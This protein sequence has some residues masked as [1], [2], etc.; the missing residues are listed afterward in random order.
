MELIRRLLFI[1]QRLTQCSTAG[2]QC[3]RRFLVLEHLDARRLMVAEGELYALSRTIDTSH[4]G[5]ALS[6]NII[7]GD[8]TTSSGQVEGGRGPEKVRVRVDYSLDTSNFFTAPRR[9]LLQSVVDSIAGK[10]SDT[11]RPIEPSGSN[12]W[13]ATLVHPSTGQLTTQPNLRIAADEIL[14]FA[15]A[16]PMPG[17]Q[18]GEGGPGGFSVA[19]SSQFISDVATRGQGTVSGGSATD[20]GPWGGMVS[21]DSTADWYFGTD[22][23]ALPAG[24]SDFVSLAAHEF[25]H[26][27]GFGTSD[28]WKRHV[29][30]SVFRGPSAKAQYDGGGDVPLASDK[31]HWQLDLMDNGQETLMDPDQKVGTRKVLTP[32][33]WGA[34]KDIGWQF[35]PP[36]AKVTA[37]HAFP[38]NGSYPV[39]VTVVGSQ[40]GTATSG[41]Q[42]NVTNAVPQLTVV[43]SQTV[44]VGEPLTLPK[45]V[46]ISDP[47]FRNTQV[48]PP[49]DETFT[50]EITW[51]DGS[52]VSRGSATIDRVGSAALATL[53]SVSASHTFGQAGTYRVDV[54]VRDDDGA[55]ASGSF[56]VTVLA[57]PSLEI[58][59]NR[60]RIH[61]DGSLKATITL[62]RRNGQLASPL[63]VSVLSSDTTEATVP[64]TVSFAANQTSLT[65]PVEPVDDDLLDGDQTIQIRASAPGVTPVAVDLIVADIEKLTAVFEVAT[66]DENAGPR[67]A[68]LRVTRSNTDTGNPLTVQVQGGNPLTLRP[69]TP[70]IIPVGQQTSTFFLDAIDDQL[71]ER[72][73][74]LNYSISA[75]G[76]LGATASISVRDN[77][78][79]KFR[80]PANPLDVNGD[81][82][83]FPVDALLVINYLNRQEQPTSLDPNSSGPGNF[84][85][86]NGDYEVTPADALRVIN[87]LNRGEGEGEGEAKGQSA[88][89]R[90]E[91][92]QP[93]RFPAIEREWFNRDRWGLVSAAFAEA[94]DD[95]S[96]DDERLR[97][98]FRR[99]R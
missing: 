67:A 93:A 73:E 48:N 83:V 80:N 8:G 39:A 41:F 4:L 60:S 66:I 47:G 89:F 70:W 34:L 75:T 77:E 98:C 72:T 42:L 49:T 97:R 69:V 74:Q 94:I 9:A 63:T 26:V 6:A 61:E 95:E 24:K 81:G 87:A 31:V 40:I 23:A 22:L 76:Y 12:T 15:G 56:T 50:Y 21:F 79:P 54:G 96:R 2:G 45:I 68:R 65:F 64:A 52:P 51:G 14:V 85:D 88:V 53:A 16:R 35:S 25:T 57:P 99:S 11:L 46:Q 20:F 59:S 37:T 58:S 86:V 32:L 7:W 33:D 3:G 44:L 28:S 82:R 1:R 17:L 84:I 90:D 18:L 29:A 43:G 38:D 10:L 5:G 78:P 30:G 62:T 13:T 19:G 55:S 27:L 71:P 36:S 91:P 92:I